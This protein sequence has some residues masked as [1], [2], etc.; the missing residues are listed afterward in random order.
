MEYLVNGKKF[1]NIEEARQYEDAFRKSNIESSSDN[2]KDSMSRIYKQ[3]IR[4]KLHVFKVTREQASKPKYIGIVADREHIK[5]LHALLGTPYKLENSE[6]IQCWDCT[7]LTGRDIINSVV[8]SFVY[9]GNIV[10]VTSKAHFECCVDACE[11]RKENPY[12]IFIARGIKS[13]EDIVKD[14]IKTGEKFI[15]LTNK[16][17]TSAEE[18]FDIFYSLGL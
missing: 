1:S 18:L 7:K 16:S 11:K 12:F 8:D 17:I 2:S 4:S 6:L 10:P 3:Y 13:K 15:E 9:G 5:Y 14:Y